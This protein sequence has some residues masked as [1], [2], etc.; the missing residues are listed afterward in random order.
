MFLALLTFWTPQYDS[1]Q[2]DHIVLH[3][4]A[5]GPITPAMA[6]YLDRGLAE[7]QL[8]E[9]ELLLFSLDTPG[10][11]IDTMNRMVQSIRASRVP[12]VVYIEPRGAI[13]ASA[14]TVITLAGHAAAMAP[15]TA[16]GAASPVG[17][18]GEDLGET[19]EAK[20]KE[21]M[22]ATVRS[23]ASGR[24][25]E[26]VRLA[27]ETIESARA[28]S[29]LE[30]LE[31]G[32]ID[33][34]AE[35]ADDLLLQLNGY[36]VETVAGSAVLSTAQAEVRNLPQSSIEQLLQALTDPTLVFLLLTIGVQAILIE[37][38]SPG[39]WVA[40]FIGL[41]SLLLAVYGLGILPVNWVG[42]IFVLAAFVLF[43]LEIKA[44]THGALAAVGVGSLIVGG[45]VLFNSPGVPGFAR[46]SLPSLV[47]MALVIAGTFMVIVGFA[48]RA[49]RKPIETGRENL[50]GRI[51]IVRS[52]LAPQ[53]SIL[54]RGEIWSA[55][56]STP[57]TVKAG[58][59]VEIAEVN[60]LTVVVR[61]VE[62]DRS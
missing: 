49:Q 36:R 62:N 12:V 33:F 15:E 20:E 11:S 24:G 23:L 58:E 56:L 57:G 1:L 31:V 43:L 34:I 22:K 50:I 8:T 29:S 54:L 53:G 40:G 38:S 17:G 32:L 51:A 2:S 27:E 16:I 4:Q 44:T 26:A 46:I 59:Q 13:A 25:S 6:E 37:L 35:D 41:C 21:I 5:S 14:G 9:A 30:A 3:L 47:L 45:L 60:G 48:L 61:P 52:D 18:Q 42:L 28:V 19:I 7:A 39:G 55:V 10:G